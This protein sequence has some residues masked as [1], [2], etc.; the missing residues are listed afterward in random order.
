M[1]FSPSNHLVKA[2]PLPLHLGYLFV[3]I[4]HSSVGGCSAESCNFRVLAED[5]H[6]RSSSGPR[7]AQH[8]SVLLLPAPPPHSWRPPPA[9]LPEA[10]PGLRPPPQSAPH[11]ILGASCSPRDTADRHPSTSPHSP[12]LRPESYHRGHSRSAPSVLYC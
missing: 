12:Q 7:W 9:F 6:T 1:R 4:Q 3:G 11:A 10:R 5:K 8:C 2:S